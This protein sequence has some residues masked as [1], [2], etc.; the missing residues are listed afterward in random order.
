M[1]N[2]LKSENINITDYLIINP[3]T[4]INTN[5]NI[6]LGNKISYLDEII[7]TKE[8]KILIITLIQIN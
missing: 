8:L 2:I 7:N 1:H 3:E 5:Y 6:Y 4:I